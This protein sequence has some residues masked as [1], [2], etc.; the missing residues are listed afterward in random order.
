MALPLVGDQI[1]LA[2]NGSAQPKASARNEVAAPR[3]A[4][5]SGRTDIKQV[6]MEPTA[7]LLRNPSPKSKS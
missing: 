2:T 4:G 7:P 5:P 3:V 6:P 1:S